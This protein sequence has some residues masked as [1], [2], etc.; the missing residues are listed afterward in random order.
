[1]VTTRLGAALAGNGGSFWGYIKTKLLPGYKKI[2]LRAWLPGHNRTTRTRIFRNRE[3]NPENPEDP[4]G[5]P[6]VPQNFPVKTGPR[7]R[8]DE[9]EPGPF[10][11]GLPPKG[12]NSR[13]HKHHT[14]KTQAFS[15]PHKVRLREILVCEKTNSLAS[16]SACAL[17]AVRTAC[18]RLRFSRPTP[19]T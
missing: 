8:Q 1:M 11:F 18:C 14:R 9:A 5:V 13:Q 6:N 15:R 12:Q 2:F 7:L 17:L 3:N 19:L 16:V 4:K 10:V